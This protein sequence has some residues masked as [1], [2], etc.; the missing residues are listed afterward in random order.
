MRFL[1]VMIVVT[2]ED[3]DS[4]EMHIPAAVFMRVVQAT[5]SQH[6]LDG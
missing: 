4:H 3:S 2:R 1:K 6:L 5:L